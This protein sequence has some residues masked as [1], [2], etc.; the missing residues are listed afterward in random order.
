MLHPCMP[1]SLSTQQNFAQW[2][3]WKIFRNVKIFLHSR[4]FSSGLSNWQNSKTTM[5]M[6][7][8]T[9]I[10]S[11]R[12]HIRIKF[13]VEKAIHHDCNCSICEEHIVYSNQIFGMA[14]FSNNEAKIQTQNTI[15][16]CKCM[17]IAHMCIVYACSAFSFKMTKYCILS[18]KTIERTATTFKKIDTGIASTL[19]IA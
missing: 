14:I 4:K 3:E 5:T 8:V 19:C 15:C 16:M 13:Y 9:F 7:T 18:N 6:N 10:P 12:E 1:F 17:H 11:V 2:M